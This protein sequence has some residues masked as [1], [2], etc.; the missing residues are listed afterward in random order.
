MVHEVTNDFERC[1][2][3]ANDH[4]R[5]QFGHRHGP[6][7]QELSRFS[8]RPEVLGSARLQAP[9]VNDASQSA[10]R[11]GFA[12][13]CC[14]KAVAS[15]EIAT[16]THRMHQV[17]GDFD[18]LECAFKGCPVE[19]VRLNC[20]HARPTSAFENGP[21]AR[22]RPDGVAFGNQP[23]DEVRTHVT[24]CS[25][26]RYSH[27]QDPLPRATLIPDSISPNW[28][29]NPLATRRVGTTRWLASR[30]SSADPPRST[31]RAIEGTGNS[32]GR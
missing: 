6:S 9:K 19:R 29:W 8:A 13:V 4:A 16:G 22:H 2:T 21:S 18:S 27:L 20:F 28:N 31:L 15:S 23:R 32:A 1:R 10:V 26:Y 7:A 30:S 11:R 17:V 25:D 24:T 3:G 5:P 12:E 14:R